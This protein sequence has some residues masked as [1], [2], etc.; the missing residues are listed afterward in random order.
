M[1]CRAAPCRAILSHT[2][3]HGHHMLRHAMACVWAWAWVWAWAGAWAWIWA[4]ANV[5]LRGVA[6][7][8]TA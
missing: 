8:N 1:A 6:W 5:P 4:W 2:M 3:P 7:L